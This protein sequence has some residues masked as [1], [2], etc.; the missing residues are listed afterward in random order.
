MGCPRVTRPGSP[1]RGRGAVWG[2]PAGARAAIGG[3]GIT[4]SP[5]PLQAWR[6]W[7]A[8]RAPRGEEARKKGFQNIP[9]PPRHEAERRPRSP[10]GDPPPVAPTPPA[11]REGTPGLILPASQGGFAAVPSR[12]MGCPGVWGASLGVSR[13]LGVWGCLGGTPP[14][15]G[16]SRWWH[17]WGVS[18][19][20]VHKWGHPAAGIPWGNGGVR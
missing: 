7:R 2:R 20:G 18:V 13:G 10:L 16:S 14:P 15:R 6:G 11:A 5:A 17:F 1:W 9:V 4:P 8:G 19:L 12:C 3:V